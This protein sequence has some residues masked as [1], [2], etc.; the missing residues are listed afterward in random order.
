MTELTLSPNIDS[1]DDFAN[2][3]RA[4]IKKTYE[5]QADAQIGKEAE[6]ISGRLQQAFALLQA[7]CQ[8]GALKLDLDPARVLPGA[9][10]AAVDGEASCLI[11]E[12]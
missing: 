11:G 4:Y 12:N 5:D 7:D 10:P 2:E 6:T 3:V 9:E 8:N 1:P